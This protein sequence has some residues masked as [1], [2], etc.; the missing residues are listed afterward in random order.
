MHDSSAVHLPT[1]NPLNRA[2]CFF[3]SLLL[4]TASLPTSAFASSEASST[5][6]PTQEQVIPLKTNKK[7]PT[8]AKSPSLEASASASTPNKITD[9]PAAGASPAPKATATPTSPFIMLPQYSGQQQLSASG[10]GSPTWSSS[11]TSVATIDSSGLVH[12]QAEGDA[13][14]TA[15]FSD[16]TSSQYYVSVYYAYPQRKTA[17]VYASADGS[18]L[19]SWGMP[20]NSDYTGDV[21]T[22]GDTVTVLYRATLAGST[23]VLQYVKTSSGDE[24]WVSHL[25]TNNRASS[26]YYVDLLKGS[27]TFISTASSAGVAYT[28]NTWSSDNSA[29]ATVVSATDPS[30]NANQGQVTGLSEGVARVSAAAPNGLYNTSIVSVYSPVGPYTGAVNKTTDELQGADATCNTSQVLTSG[31]TLSITGQCGNYWRIGSSGYFVAKS[32]VTIQAD[33]ITL[34][35][36]SATIYEGSAFNLTATPKPALATSG[37]S[38]SSSNSA[39]ASVDSSGK[40]TAYKAG[41][42]TITAKS[43]DITGKSASCKITVYAAAQKI[44]LPKTLVVKTGATSSALKATLSPSN[45][46]VGALT[47]GTNYTNRLTSVAAGKVTAATQSK[48]PNGT[49]AYA[50]VKATPKKPTVGTTPAPTSA[51]TFVSV[52]AP[53]TLSVAT[54][55]A[56]VVLLT[57]AGQPTAFPAYIAKVATVPTADSLLTVLGSCGNY[58]YVQLKSN[59]TI[60]GFV[61]KSDTYQITLRHYTPILNQTFVP[62]VDPAA[63]TKIPLLLSSSTASKKVTV[64]V[65]ALAGGG[66]VTLIKDK[67]GN[68]TGA[69]TAKTSGKFTSLKVTRT[70]KVTTTDKSGKKATTT[71]TSYY[72]LHI[73]IPKLRTPEIGQIITAD[74]QTYDC[75]ANTCPTRKLT[76]GTKVK[77]L[78]AI[79]DSTGKIYKLQIQYSIGKATE[80]RYIFYKDVKYISVSPTVMNTNGAKTVNKPI[81]YNHFPNDSSRDVSTVKTGN[82][83]KATTTKKS[84]SVDVK[85]IAIGYTTLTTKVG[86]DIFICY[87]PVTVYSPMAYNY[88]GYLNTATDLMD[89]AS[90][91]GYPVAIA[92]LKKGA[93]VTILGQCPGWFYIQTTI[94]STA[95][96]GFVPKSAVV[97]VTLTQYTKTLNKN[98]TATIG[99]LLHNAPKGTKLVWKVS[100]T[101]AAINASTGLITPKKESTFLVW[102][103]TSNGLAISPTCFVSAYTAMASPRGY[104]KQQDDVRQCATDSTSRPKKGGINQYTSFTILGKCGS[105]FLIKKVDGTTGWVKK[106]KVVYITVSKSSLTLY[107]YHTGTLSAYLHNSYSDHSIVWSSSNSSVASVKGSNGNN[108]KTGTVSA[109]KPGTTTLKATY[110]YAT[111]NGKARS[112]SATANVK[113]KDIYITLNTTSVSLT[114]T[115]YSEYGL[116]DK[117][118]YPTYQLTAKIYTWP[119]EKVTWTSS[120]SNKVSVDKNG[121]I[122]ALRA[123]TAT[124]TARYKDITKSCQVTATEKAIT[125]YANQYAYSFG[126]DYRPAG[127]KGLFAT[128]GETYDT[129]QGAIDAAADFGKAGYKSYYNITPTFDYLNGNSPNTGEKRLSS[130]ILFFDGHGA[131]NNLTFH[132]QQKSGGYFTGVWIYPTKAPSKYG[133]IY[134]GIPDI[135]MTNVKLVTFAACQTAEPGKHGVDTENLCSAAIGQ[136]AKTAVGWTLEVRIDSFPLWL[137][138]YTDSLSKGSA[139]SDAIYY[140]DSFTDYKSSTPK[141]AVIYGSPMTTIR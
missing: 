49:I 118:V 40:V 124:I 89:G 31:K 59:T 42:V 25:T 97:Y 4:I 36:S 46:A 83:K 57:G 103:Q 123:G 14:I 39:I 27:D 11:D 140:A 2:L 22:G 77:I 30:G 102:V 79:Y 135:P 75:A 107:R 116:P 74:A 19:C 125:L 17:Q 23:D 54:K 141:S 139:V 44:T 104:M 9:T 45:A 91:N 71:T 101:N 64:S 50:S 114:I 87:S 28:D 29:I 41:T 48:F 38:Y 33:S 138:R 37:L 108:R 84:R 32:D 133:G 8:P 126:T 60:K 70:V 6:P 127:I 119:N 136:G 132:Y 90:T 5:A 88:K 61:A 76:L 66:N 53:L 68:Y 62:S 43:K 85:R 3:F 12:A 93:A 96:R 95:F 34:N 80:T 99:Y 117:F 56:R 18:P 13:T 35:P 58:Y 131:Y 111:V 81:S 134:V 98:S 113:V 130:P 15:A 110:K 20:G 137:R 94:G 51:K 121:K 78:G 7:A 105:F 120:D 10:T 92:S 82:P 67:S 109:N 55:K 72:I 122:T 128:G 86:N 21:L 24:G 106:S 52:Y 65:K 112:I 100:N 16:G 129:T 63:T 73:T 69:I 115:K 47:W 1:S 26:P